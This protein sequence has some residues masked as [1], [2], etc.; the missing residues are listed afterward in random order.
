MREAFGFTGA[1]VVGA[2]LGLLLLGWSAAAVLV[3]AAVAGARALLSIDS[4]RRTRALRAGE[5]RRAG[6]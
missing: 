2:V 4:S 3:L 5:H 1:V 6:A